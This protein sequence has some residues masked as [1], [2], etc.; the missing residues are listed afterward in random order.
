MAGAL[1]GLKV[2]DLTSHVSGPYCTMLLADLGA[3][4]IKVERPGAGDDARRMPPF[5]GGEGAPFMLI[6]RNKRSLVLD[7]K[8]PSDLALCRALAAQADVV[9]ENFKPGTMAQLGLGYQALSAANPRLIYA[10]ISGFGQ[11]G[12]LRDLGGFDL[13]IQA[14]SGLMSVCGDPDGPP[15]RLPAPITDIAAGMFAAIGI[16]AALAARERTG[17]GQQVESS[18]FESGLAFGI[19]E[20]AGFFATGER[21]ERLGQGH[22]G[23]VPY[24]VF[25][26]ADGWLTI[27]G[28]TQALWVKLCSAIGAAELLD[29]PRFVDNASRVA[30]RAALVPMLQQRLIAQPTQ[31]WVGTLE[32]AGIP[33]GPVWS[34]DEVLVHEHTIARQMVREIDHPRAGRQRTL[35]T[36]VK[37]SHTPSSIRRPAPVLGEHGAE[38]RAALDRGEWPGRDG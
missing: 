34:Y 25:E 36:P 10:A 29:D 16:L 32:A 38:I 5:V 17:Q 6:N 37:L 30:H 33:F 14:M 26:T 13:M 24:Q 19:Y 15:H 4:V 7:L 11:T 23:S 20:A 1:D 28:A 9:T 12:P 35:G 31:H 3:D 8:A 18:L 2:V 21:P 27:G 22:R